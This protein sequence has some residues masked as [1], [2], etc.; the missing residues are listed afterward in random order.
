ML[1]LDHLPSLIGPRDLFANKAGTARADRRR[2]ADSADSADGH[3][4]GSL[5]SCCAAAAGHEEQTT[6]D[7]HS[8]TRDSG[9]PS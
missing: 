8:E 4:V 3:N 6:R 1:F 7:G 5:H 9:W 2:A